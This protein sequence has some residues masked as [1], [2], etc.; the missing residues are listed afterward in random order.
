[1]FGDHRGKRRIGDQQVERH[2]RHTQGSTYLLIEVWLMEVSLRTSGRSFF[3]STD[4]PQ[5]LLRM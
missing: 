3:I 1:M 4:P 5:R 2:P